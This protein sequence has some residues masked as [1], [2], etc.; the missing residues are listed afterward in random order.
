MRETTPILPRTVCSIR[1]CFLHVLNL[2][3]LD[4][5]YSNI[6]VIFKKINIFLKNFFIKTCPCSCARHLC[7]DT[8]D[9]HGNFPA[10]F[11]GLDHCSTRLQVKGFESFEFSWRSF[12]FVIVIQEI[13]KF[14][15]YWLIVDFYIQY[16]QTSLY[17]DLKFHRT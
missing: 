7:S 12:E 4:V 3:C 5:K 11:P 2:L 6:Q 15:F 8:R 14:I 9:L 16:R 10:Q 17:A 1:I 13:R